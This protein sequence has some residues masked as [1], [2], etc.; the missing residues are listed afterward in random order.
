MNH[1]RLG[2]LHLQ[3]SDE[4]RLLSAR[5]EK[6]EATWR[7]DSQVKVARGFWGPLENA[8]PPALSEL[9]EIVRLVEALERRIEP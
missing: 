5:W 1:N 4:W 3:L 6:A 2:E 9:E 8:V 7:D